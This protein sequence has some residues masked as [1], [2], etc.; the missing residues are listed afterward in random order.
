[1]AYDVAYDV[2]EIIRGP[3][4]LIVI[5]EVHTSLAVFTPYNNLS[6]MNETCS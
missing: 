3:D 6:S 2:R 4:D 1:M 5:K